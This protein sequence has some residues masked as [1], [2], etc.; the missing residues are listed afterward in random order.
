M[1]LD[2]IFKAITLL[3]DEIFLL[4]VLPIV[5]F[6]RR[7]N[8]LKLAIS[9]LI[10][11]YIA[12]LLKPIFRIPRP[13]RERWKVTASGYSFPSGHATNSMA[14]WGYAAYLTRKRSVLSTLLI[15]VALMVGYSRVYLG[16]HWWTDVIAGWILGAVV[17]I[18]IEIVDE[19]CSSIIQN[20]SYEEKLFLSMV[21]PMGLILASMALIGV[22]VSEFQTI[23][24][25]LST[26][27]GMLAGYVIADKRKLLLADT[28]NIK[29]ILI[30]SLIGLLLV[31]ALY[32][33]YE[34]L[35]ALTIFIIIPTFWL[36]GV[37]VTLFTPYIMSQLT[38]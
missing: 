3:G 1:L 24:K 35:K 21:I 27:S 32:I 28:N 8:G 22:N 30:R 33:I 38:K 36:I 18:I 10:S 15:I 19:R 25:V 29:T 17:F 37:S 23:L 5:F 6:A 34:M 4:I 26:L 13:S 7:R 20:I 9:V 12:H 14:F 2:S 31:I 11:V 16:V